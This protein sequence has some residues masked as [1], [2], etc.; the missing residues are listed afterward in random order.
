MLRCEPEVVGSLR[1]TTFH[2]SVISMKR[3][4]SAFATCALVLG[5]TVLPKPSLAQERCHSA[6]SDVCVDMNSRPDTTIGVNAGTSG[7]ALCV[8]LGE[9]QGDNP[10]VL[11]WNGKY[12]ARKIGGVAGRSNAVAVRVQAGKVPTSIK[13]Y[14]PG[15]PY[16]IEHYWTSCSTKLARNI[17]NLQWRSR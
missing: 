17:E 8:V 16:Q 10:V 2:L 12:A 13:V 3:L 1:L 9:W 5:V 7:R 4:F 6:Y 15:S 11:E 14:S